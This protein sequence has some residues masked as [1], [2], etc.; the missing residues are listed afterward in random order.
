[1]NKKQKNGQYKLGRYFHKSSGYWYLTMIYDHPNSNKR[2]RITEHIYNFTM[3]HKCS[4]LKW[5]IV[6]HLDEN[7][8]NNMPWNLIGTV[9]KKHLVTHQIWLTRTD[10]TWKKISMTKQNNKITV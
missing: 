5:G 9:R 4:M 6:H 10:E 8:E 2:G 3:F 1:M 7:K